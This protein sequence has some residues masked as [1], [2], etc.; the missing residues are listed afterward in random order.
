MCC[1]VVICCGGT[2]ARRSAESKMNKIV[3]IWLIFND[4]F[5]CIESVGRSIL[6]KLSCD[7]IV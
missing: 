2:K 4:F 5:D 1:A 7:G 3:L 6:Y